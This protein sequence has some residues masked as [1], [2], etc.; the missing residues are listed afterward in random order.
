MAYIATTDITDVLVNQFT[1]SFS[2]YHTLTDSQMVDIA[3]QIGVTDSDDISTDDDGYVSSFFIRQYLVAWFCMR[4]L[5]DK[6]GIN[7]VEF[8]ETE[9]YRV[10]YEYYMAIVKYKEKRITHEM[11]TGNV[12]EVGDRSAGATSGLIFRG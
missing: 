12:D 10:K 9:K 8:A 11:I 4:L 2:T 7:N 6:M 1:S 3:E 5:F